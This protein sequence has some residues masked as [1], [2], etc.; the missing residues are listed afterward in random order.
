MDINASTLD[1]LAELSKLQFSEEEKV[2]L[3][4]DLQN[5]LQFVQKLNEIDTTGI[6][7]LMH[8]TQAQNNFRSDAIENA[9]AAEDALKPAQHTINHFFTVP[10]V[11]KKQ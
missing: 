11:I 5:M 1:K 6:E 3:Q 10:K 9:F 4:Q 2:V 8:I 7:P